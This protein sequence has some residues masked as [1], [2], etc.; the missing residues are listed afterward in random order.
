MMFIRKHMKI[1]NVRKRLVSE[2]KYRYRGRSGRNFV[3]AMLELQES[4]VHCKNV[5]KRL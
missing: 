1:Q 5:P 3:K 4:E 2:K